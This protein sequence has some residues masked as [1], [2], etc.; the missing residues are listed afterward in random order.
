MVNAE[1]EKYV[2]LL[3][4]GAWIEIKGPDVFDQATPSHSFAGVRGLKFKEPGEDKYEIVS[5]SF[6]GVRGLK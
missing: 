1:N 3:R 6:A 2:A 4:G 5:H